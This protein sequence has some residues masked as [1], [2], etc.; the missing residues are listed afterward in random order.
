MH[1]LTDG[2]KAEDQDQIKVILGTTDR[3]FMQADTWC[4][5]EHEREDNGSC[6]FTHK[7][8]NILCSKISTCSQRCQIPLRNQNS[9]KTHWHSLPNC[10]N[11]WFTDATWSSCW[12]WCRGEAII[13]KGKNKKEPLFV[14]FLSSF[15]PSKVYIHR[16]S[17]TELPETCR[18]GC[19]IRNTGK[20]T[21]K[22]GRIPFL[23][24][25]IVIG[26]GSFHYLTFFLVMLL[27]AYIYI[28]MYYIISYLLST[29][30]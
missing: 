5:K 13:Q 4:S 12:S 18:T 15:L 8:T 24:F 2:T 27:S 30:H 25:V 9:S 14:P 11:N 3:R 10:S 16:H 6:T 23:S 29:N 26:I 17:W 22:V 20:R 1:G 7:K 19:P 28:Y 21:K